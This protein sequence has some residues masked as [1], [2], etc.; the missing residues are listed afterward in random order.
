VSPGQ[1]HRATSCVRAFPHFFYFVSHRLSIEQEAH[2]KPSPAVVWL[3]TTNPA[4]PSLIHLTILPY[5]NSP[6]RLT[7]YRTEGIDVHCIPS[8]RGGAS[9]SVAVVIVS[10]V[11]PLDV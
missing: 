6:R 10:I 3:T 11:L 4:I 8:L 2:A 1:G 5:S 9:P 7:T